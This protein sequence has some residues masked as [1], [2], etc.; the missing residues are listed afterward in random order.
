MSLRCALLTT[1][2][3]TTVACA[4]LP[5]QLAGHDTGATHH[6]G[7]VQLISDA[8]G[9]PAERDLAV[10]LP[11]EAEPLVRASTRAADGDPLLSERWVGQVARAFDGTFAEGAIGGESIYEDWRLVSARVVPRAP[12]ARSPALAPASVCWPMVR[13]VWQPV[14]PGVN[15][16]GVVFDSYADDRAIHALYPVHPRDDSGRRAATTAYVRVADHLGRGGRVSELSDAVL[17]DFDRS[18]DDTARALPARPTCAR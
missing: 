5:L 7:E 3:G 14:A 18:R 15:L 1:L 17:D 11:L 4:P 12:V 8:E 10:L 13:L 6:V 9:F 16:W 2:A